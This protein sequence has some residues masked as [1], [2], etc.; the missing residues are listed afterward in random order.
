MNCHKMCLLDKAEQGQKNFVMLDPQGY[1][2]LVDYKGYVTLKD[3]LELDLSGTDAIKVDSQEM[4]GSYR[5]PTRIKWYE[6]IAVTWH[7]ICYLYRASDCSSTS[8]ENAL[9]AERK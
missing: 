4:A 1:L 8:Q 5:G 3:K 6:D 9:L 2:R 7:R